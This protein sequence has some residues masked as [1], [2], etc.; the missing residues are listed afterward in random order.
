M[1]K[2]KSYLFYFLILISSR[3]IVLQDKYK[4]I[5]ANNGKEG[6]QQLEKQTP[7]LILTD[8][9][10][11][12]MNGFEFMKAVKQNEKWQQIPIIALT[13]RSE[14][15]DKLEALRIGIDDYLVKP[16]HDEELKIR[17]QNLL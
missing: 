2:F 13:A 7:D 3:T 1:H 17:I 14:M 9:M 4:I 16:F 5:L 12:V 11:P 6:L 10:M 15:S 8:L